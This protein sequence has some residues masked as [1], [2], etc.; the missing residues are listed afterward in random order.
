MLK[1][2]RIRIYPNKQQKILIDKTFGCCR[3]IYNKGLALRKNTYENEGKS[4]GY[5]ETSAMLTS[6]KKEESF[7][8]LKEVDSIALQQSLRDLDKA[9]KNFFRNK[10]GYPKFH[11]KHDSF[12]SY[13]TQ[14]VHPNSICAT[15]DGKHIKLPKLG[16]VKAKVTYDLSSAKINNATIERMSSGKYFCV[17]NVEVDTPSYSND[18]CM[19]GIDLGIKTFYTDSNNFVCENKKLISKSAKKLRKEQRKLSRM[20]ESHII[21]YE[22]GKKGDHIPIYNKPLSECKNIQKQ[23]IKV[24]R[25]HEHIANQ[26]NDFLQKESTKIVKEN[27]LIALEDLAVKNMVHNHK[28]AKSIYDVSWSKFVTMLEY[29]APLYG[30]EIVKVPRFYASS[31]IC[32]CCGRQNPKVKNL[33]VRDWICPK[34]GTHHDRDH[35]ASINILNKALEIRKAS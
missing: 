23:R 30:T 2:L 7:Y 34:C 33:S 14:N 25:I 13:R 16:Y 24:A 10:F 32:S 3:L 9:Y 5:K 18:G 20:I 21:G 27:Q 12:A 19:V 22:Q 8:F 11:S 31:Q 17:L 29:K 28:L 15:L 35:N 6:L 26:R 1:G 4:I